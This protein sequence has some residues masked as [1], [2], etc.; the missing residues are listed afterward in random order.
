MSLV[1]IGQFF[2]A[3]KNVHLVILGLAANIGGYKEACIIMVYFPN[4]LLIRIR[5]LYISFGSDWI[6][7]INL[8]I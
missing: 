3:L 1:N 7:E 4:N 2:C 8:I 6:K 5:V